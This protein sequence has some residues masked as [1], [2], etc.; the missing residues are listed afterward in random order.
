MALSDKRAIACAPIL[1]FRS[2]LTSV[3]ADYADENGFVSGEFG[4]SQNLRIV[5]DEVFC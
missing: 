3:T 1:V 4:Y 2:L 5:G